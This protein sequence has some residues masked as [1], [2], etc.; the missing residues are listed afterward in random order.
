M[1]ECLQA[2]M[3]PGRKWLQGKEWLQAGM[4]ARPPPVLHLLALEQVC[5]IG[6]FR[7]FG[8]AALPAVWLPSMAEQARASCNFDWPG[9][10]WKTG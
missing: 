7:M 3:A 10:S 5:R 2:G 1:Q 6:H 8:F 4:A 9:F